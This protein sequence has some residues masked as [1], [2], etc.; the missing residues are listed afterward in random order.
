MIK[1]EEYCDAVSRLSFL[2]IPTTTNNSQTTM[3]EVTVGEETDVEFD[4]TFYVP[5]GF[6]DVLS[7]L[8]AMGS[9]VGD[10]FDCWDRRHEGPPATNVISKLEKVKGL[11]ADVS[12]YGEVAVVHVPKGPCTVVAAW[13]HS[14][15]H[16]AG[17]PCVF[18]PTQNESI[19]SW[20]TDAVVVGCDTTP[21]GR[22]PNTPIAR[23]L[24]WDLAAA[25]GYVL[26][27]LDE[28]ALVEQHSNALPFHNLH[29]PIA[30]RAPMDKTYMGVSGAVITD[31]TTLHL[32][33]CCDVGFQTVPVV[34]GCFVQD[35]LNFKKA[36]VPLTITERMTRVN[37]PLVFTDGLSGTTYINAHMGNRTFRIDV[38]ERGSFG[39]IQWVKI[40]SCQT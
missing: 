7:M 17:I 15:V 1:P 39:G 13:T 4:I 2:V 8:T 30:K 31:N 32:V 25:A 33:T 28:A 3:V 36:H 38:L 20:R 26:G 22:A 24:R 37:G 40:E 21:Y 19:T 29:F 23:S 9:P 6:V 12:G 11:S 35:T 10:A 34:C 16:N 5:P 18:V 27:A 14:M